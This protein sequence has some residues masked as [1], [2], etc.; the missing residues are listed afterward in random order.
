MTQELFTEDF[1]AMPVG[2]VA[3]DYTPAGEYHVVPALAESGRWREV[4]I[5]HSFRK[6][7]TSRGNWQVVEDS[8]GRRALEQTVVSDQHVP[9]LAAGGRTWQVSSFSVEI[10]PWTAGGVRQMVFRYLTANS[11]D[12]IEFDAGTVRLIRRGPFAAEVLAEAPGSLDVEDFTEVTVSCEGS[13]LAVSVGGEPILDVEDAPGRQGRGGIALAADHPTRFRAVR[14]TGKLRPEGRRAVSPA[15][16]IRPHLWKRFST[17]QWGTDRNLRFADLTGNG[18]MD[19]VMA[20]RTDRL[21][22]DNFSTISSM[23]AMTLEGET[24]WQRGTPSRNAFATTSDLCFQVHDIDGDGVPEV[25]FSQDWDLVI[26]DPVHDREKARM[27][28]PLNEVAAAGPLHRAL[29]DSLYFCDL[30]GSGRDDSILL[31]D[32]YRQLWALTSELKQLWSFH[33]T[34]GHYPFAADIDGD[35][36]DEVFIGHHLIDDDGTPLW[37]AAY[38][39]HS[40]NVAI[41][42]T[43]LPGRHGRVFAIAGSDAGFILLDQQGRELVRREIGHAQSMCFA[44]LLPE[45]DG[46]EFLVNTFW[47]RV[48]VHMVFDERGEV[49]REFE[50]IPYA[51]LLEPVNWLPAGFAD[52]PADLVL[53][54]THPRQGGLID[55]NGARV[56][57]FPDDG[58]P[59]MCSAVCDLDGDGV[60]EILTWD[61]DEIWVYKADVPGRDPGNYPRRNKRYNDSNYRAQVSLPR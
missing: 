6:V 53:L 4:V 60:D 3:G 20:R 52:R 49:L 14:V 61:E 16:G 29:G 57:E 35:G 13:R 38:P 34:L 54:S 44:N 22:S 11:H 59:W 45:R 39:D 26:H 58:H 7:L 48:G 50:P 18:T 1:E 55:G 51:T 8:R 33:G 15:A 9:M 2:V 42:E 24:I 21:G 27:R 17:G 30:T 56:V 5:H 43:G 23:A 37:T 19:V 12:L 46:M 47:G 40:D 25:I 41:L 36:R 28:M 31:K 10:H 32:R